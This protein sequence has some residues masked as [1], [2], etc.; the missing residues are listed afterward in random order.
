MENRLTRLLILLIIIILLF[1]LPVIATSNYDGQTKDEFTPSNE[2]S[3]VSDSSWDN[4]ITLNFA[5]ELESVT[6]DGQTFDL[7]NVQDCYYTFQPGQPQLPFKVL[8]LKSPTKL[9]S[10]EVEL[11]NSVYIANLRLAPAR[12]PEVLSLSSEGLGF[13]YSPYYKTT[14]NTGLVPKL[15]HKLNYLGAG[16]FEGE[17]SYVYNLEIYPLIYD[18]ILSTGI[19][20]Q[21]AL[22]KMDYEEQEEQNDNDEPTGATGHSTRSPESVDSQEEYIIITTDRLKD[23]LQPLLDWKIRKG[24]P[25]TMYDIVSISTDPDIDGIDIPDKLRNFLRDKYYNFGLKYVL[26]AGDYNTVPPRLCYDPNP[27]GADDGEIPSD[28]YYACLDKGTTWDY[29]GDGIYGELGDLD[30]IIPEI[31]VGR[32]AINSDTGMRDWVQANLDY[33]REPVEGTWG[34]NAHLLGTNTFYSGDGAKQSEYL[35]NKYLQDIFGSFDKLYEDSVEATEPFTVENVMNAI[36]RGATYINYLG[37]GSPTT[38]T[39]NYGYTKLMNKG[40]V[41][42]LTNGAKKPLVFAMSCDTSWFDDSSDSGW[43]NFGDC[44][45][46]TYTEFQD[47]GGIAYVGF[48]RTTVGSINQGYTPYATG[49]QEDFNRMLGRGLKNIGEIFMES[50][51]FYAQSWGASFNDTS[52]SGEVQACWVEENLLGEPELPIWTQIPQKFNITNE[53]IETGVIITVKDE[54]NEIVDNAAVCLFAEDE[55]YAVNHTNV[56]GRAIFHIASSGR[57]VNLT[58]TKPNFLPHESKLKVADIIPPETF[59]EINPASPDGKNDWYCVFPVVNLTTEP[60]AV[61][62]YRWEREGDGEGGNGRE[63]ENYT[64]L[65]PMTPPEGIS[66][67][68]F[69]SIDDSNNIEP[70]QIYNFKIDIQTPQTNIS[71]MPASPDGENGWYNSY[72]E[73]Y[74]SSPENGGRIFY[75]WDSQSEANSTSDIVISTIPPLEGLNTLYYFSEDNAGNREAERALVLKI[76]TVPSVTEIEITPDVPNGKNDWYISSPSIT[77]STEQ[78][79]TIYYS[80]DTEIKLDDSTINSLNRYSDEILTVPEGIHDLYYYSIDYAGNNEVPIHK[81]FKLD[82]ESPISSLKITPSDPDGNEDWFTSEVEIS[83]KCNDK[84]YSHLLQQSPANYA[85]PAPE[86]YY[87]WDNSETT[88]KYNG[89]ITV[90]EGEHTLYYY[91]EDAAGNVEPERSYYVKQDLTPPETELQIEPDIPDGENYWFITAPTVTFKAEDNVNPVIPEDD[92]EIEEGTIETFYY[93]DNPDARPKTYQKNLQ[94]IEGQHTLYYYSI[95]LAGNVE[96]ASSYEFKVDLIPPYSELEVD[97]KTVLIGEPV[98]FDASESFDVNGIS[99]YYIEFGDGDV[100]EWVPAPT[101]EHRY[102]LAGEYEVIM[103]VK[104]NAGRVS[105]NAATVKITV[106]EESKD[107]SSGEA[108]ELSTIIMPLVIGIILIIAGFLMVSFMRKAAAHDEMGTGY[109]DEYE[110]ERIPPEEEPRL[111]RAKKAPAAVEPAEAIIIDKPI[112]VKIQKVQCPKCSKVFKLGSRSPEIKCPSC[113]AEGKIK[114][115]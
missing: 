101:L 100:R 28:T 11:L 14:E 39:Y 2:Q 113:G 56:N 36:G 72:P 3:E 5:Y 20:Y 63:F 55:L 23:E 114:G 92:S 15:A 10:H 86:I 48:S 46:E 57:L 13:D 81:N 78:E 61:T 71:I 26:L 83:L 95:D 18:P 87:R 85:E 37:H 33:E 109:S 96:T 99:G 6:I 90:P 25:S 97:T 31:Y 112:V 43:G 64:F 40:D 50:K 17:R 29:D 42:E 54:N 67:L 51:T 74:L 80:W 22:I 32:I 62:Y 102:E 16:D 105:E 108:L 58:V 59:I 107:E 73:I 49:L 77:L 34:Q 110:V 98:S 19:F 65:G 41:R 35:L 27:Y 69:Y 91:S 111:T 1:Q 76:D 106:F 115:L 89:N 9:R 47:N 84:L 53:T 7:V 75:M 38:W 88:K 52:S 60:K 12:P 45:G 30:D 44:I 94:V 4:E 68:I 93:W 79:S 21:T 82:T 8:N 66:D 103:M 24:I 70:E 104:D